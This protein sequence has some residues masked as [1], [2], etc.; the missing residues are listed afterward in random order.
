MKV[1]VIL[2]E[3][4]RDLFSIAEERTFYLDSIFTDPETSVI[5]NPIV[6]HN[7][8][9]YLT[10]KNHFKICPT[11]TLV[12]DFSNISLAVY[13]IDQTCNR[14]ILGYHGWSRFFNFDIK[15]YNI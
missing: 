14:E 9:T 8:Y 12:A 1:N 4:S 13:S 11:N 2:R 15:S 7:I 10:K 3:N 6:K 5:K